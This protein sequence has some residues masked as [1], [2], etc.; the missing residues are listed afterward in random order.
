MV[1]TAAFCEGPSPEVL[2]CLLQALGQESGLGQD[3]LSFEEWIYSVFFATMKIQHGPGFWTC[4]GANS[5]S[6]RKGLLGVW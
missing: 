1:F 3:L 2:P 6:R 4:S 5:S